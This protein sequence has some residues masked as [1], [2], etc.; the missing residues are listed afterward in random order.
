MV[1]EGFG[2][3]GRDVNIGSNILIRASLSDEFN[4][5]SGEYFDNNSGQFSASHIDALNPKKM[6]T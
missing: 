2:I 5:T 3:D 6:N 4:N 1:R